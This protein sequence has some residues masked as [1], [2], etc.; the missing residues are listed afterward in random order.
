MLEQHDPIPVPRPP[1]D[2]GTFDILRALVRNPLEAIPDGAYRAGCVATRPFGREVVYV[3]HP[4]LVR[5]VLTDPDTFGQ[6]HVMRRALAPLLGDGVLTTEGPR[7]RHQRRAAAPAFR[8]EAVL[9]LLPL[10]TDAAEAACDRWLARPGQTVNVV[11]EMMRATLDVI[12]GALLPGAETIDRMRFG[13]ALSVYL[14][15]SGWNLALSVLRAPHWLPYPGGRRVSAR[16]AQELRSMVLS[17]LRSS[18][19]DAEAGLLPLLRSHVD[20]ESGRAFTK[21]ELLDNL[22]TFIA[23]GH[24][25]TAITLAW[26][27][28]LLARHPAIEAQVLDEIAAIAPAGRLD[29]DSLASLATTRQVVQEMMRLYPAAPLLLRTARRATTLGNVPLGAGASIYLPIYALHRHEAAW[30]RPEMFDPNRFLPEQARSQHRYAYLPFG[31]GPRACMGATLA[32]TEAVAL[33]AIILRRTR[34]SVSPGY[35]PNLSYASRS[36]RRATS[37]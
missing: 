22:L 12:L 5:H 20:P 33:L 31:A 29:A 7:W 10:M 28:F 6:D 19:G 14:E 16:A 24:E 17:V 23:A 3:A 4:D 30:S 2:A 26:A 32:M 11:A 25:T 21:T 36:G 27:L 18:A 15:Q 37:R 13:D 1:D 9:Q 8:N 34:F 35:H